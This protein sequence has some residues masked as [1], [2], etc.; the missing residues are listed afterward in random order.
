MFFMLYV[1]RTLCWWTFKTHKNA[2]MK[3]SI[4]HPDGRWV[5]LLV[6]KQCVGGP[7]NRPLPLPSKTFA[8]LRYYGDRSHCNNGNDDCAGAWFLNDWPSQLLL[9]D[10]FQNEQNRNQNGIEIKLNNLKLCS[11]IIILIM[12]MEFGDCTLS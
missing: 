10:C 1:T 6:D 3:L 4:P 12:E 9:T 5:T 7:R 2:K 11:K 8:K